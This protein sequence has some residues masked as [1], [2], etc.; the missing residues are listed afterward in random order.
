MCYLCNCLISCSTTCFW[1]RTKVIH[2]YWLFQMAWTWTYLHPAFLSLRCAY[3]DWT[4]KSFPWKCV[5][6]KWEGNRVT[7]G[8]RELDCSLTKEP[9]N[10]ISH[11]VWYG[12]TM[13]KTQQLKPYKRYKHNICSIQKVHKPSLIQNELV[14]T[15][16]L[17]KYQT[18]LVS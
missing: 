1:K 14:S 11:F 9:Q 8:E 13:F 3:K 4:I 5:E 18:I 12:V 15:F 7:L 6:N 17:K 10:Y 16:T 2:I